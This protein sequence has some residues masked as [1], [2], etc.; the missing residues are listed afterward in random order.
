MGEEGHE[1][2]L[3]PPGSACR[4]LSSPSAVVFAP[5]LTLKY[6]GKGERGA[7]VP[8]VNKLRTFRGWEATEG[9]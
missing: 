7:S 1:K 8:P 9:V 3:T 2:R 6:S 5:P 4:D